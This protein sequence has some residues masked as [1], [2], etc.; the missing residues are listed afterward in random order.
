MLWITLSTTKFWRRDWVPASSKGA[1]L[2]IFLVLLR[3]PFR[4]PSMPLSQSLHHP[5]SYFSL[6]G[7]LWRGCPEGGAGGQVSTTEDRKMEVREQAPKRPCWEYEKWKHRR[8][9]V[10]RSKYQ[11][12][13]KSKESG[14]NEWWQEWMMDGKWFTEIRMSNIAC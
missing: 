12:G 2:P 11:K 7:S 1:S 6:V 14:V 5:R 9:T 4:P 10:M 13:G 8:W 3:R